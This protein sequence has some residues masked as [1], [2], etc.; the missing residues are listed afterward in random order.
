MADKRNKKSGGSRG[1]DQDVSAR[2][3][4]GIPLSPSWWAPAFITVLIVGLLYLVVFYL[5][6]GRFPIPQI[7]NWNILV[8]VGIML[9]GFG[10]TLRWR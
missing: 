2:W 8:G 6:S 3:T 10:M 7:G 5:S 4:D 9:V 1:N